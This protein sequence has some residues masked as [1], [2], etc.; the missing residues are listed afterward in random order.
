VTLHE[1]LRAS[2]ELI[3][4]VTLIQYKQ[5]DALVLAGTTDEIYSPELR[6]GDF[7]ALPSTIPK[8]VAK[9]AKKSGFDVR[10]ESESTDASGMSARPWQG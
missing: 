7:V 5:Y 1:Q 8:N 10:A 6:K 3:E 2:C 9:S 4:P